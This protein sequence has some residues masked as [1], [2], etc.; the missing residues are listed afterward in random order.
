M[1]DTRLL[2]LVSILAQALFTLVRR[3]LMSFSFLTARHGDINLS[4]YFSLTALTNTFAGLKA[5]M[6]CSGIVIVV[7]LV[8]LRAAFWALYD[9]A[10][11][12][13][14]IDWFLHFDGL[15]DGLHE[16]LNYLLYS[17]FLNTGFA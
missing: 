9:E 7:F 15:L 2:L 14:E 1:A 4:N 11:E 3:H 10:A 8:M 13:T 5:G 12:A 17:D 6:S 16:L